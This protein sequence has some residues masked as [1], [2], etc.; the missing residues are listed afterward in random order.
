MNSRGSHS[1]QRNWLDRTS[2]LPPRVVGRRTFLAAGVA[3]ATAATAWAREY[4]DGTQPVRYPDPDIVV[5]DQR[6]AKYKLGNT[7]IQRVYH[8]DK[9]L[10][11]EGPAWNGVGRYLLWSDIPNNVQMRWLEEDGHVSTFRHP[12]ENDQ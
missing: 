11:A 2:Q 7:P 12:A 8:S 1:D 9:M 10:W 3:A 5:L 6:F 4:G